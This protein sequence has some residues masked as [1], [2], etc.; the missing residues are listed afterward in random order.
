[1]NHGHKSSHEILWG[2]YQLYSA[3][4]GKLVSELL[5]EFLPLKT[6]HILDLG[7][8]QGGTAIALAQAGAKVT[9]VD[10]DASAI[11]RLQLQ[12]AYDHV[13]ITV[14]KLSG[15]MIDTLETYH[16][17]I[18]WDVIEHVANAQL[19][20]QKIYRALKP[21]GLLLLATP[22]RYSPVNIICDPHYGLP[23]V[24]LCNRERVKKIIS[25]YLRWHEKEKPDFPELFGLC[26]LSHALTAAGF[27]WRLINKTAVAKALSNPEGLWNRS[28]HLQF[29]KTVK[30]MRSNQIV[31]AVIS[32]RC[33]FFNQYIQPTFFVLAR[34]E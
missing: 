9:A 33:N 1:M 3:A 25:L 5:A 24:A 13:D 17:V 19:V 20:L 22:N 6:S 7:C 34:K 30:K 8:G 12:M 16:A 18:L 4:R 31:Q 23:L 15:E 32:D 21:G 10:P 29:F 26:S 2:N 28:W 27:S 14:K 11:S